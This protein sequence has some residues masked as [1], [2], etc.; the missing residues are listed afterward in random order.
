MSGIAGLLS[1][2]GG[3]IDRCLLGRLT[4]FM[5]FRGPDAQETWN[6]GRVGFGHAMLRTTFESQRERQPCS[7]DDRVW[8][9][10]DARVDGRSELSHKLRSA[11][12]EFQ[13]GAND[14]ELILYAYRAWGEECVRHLLGD[15]AFAIWDGPRERLF[16]ARDHFGVKPF[17][18][19]QAGDCAV[20]SNTLNCVRQHPAVSDELNELAIADFL[21]FDY[22]QDEATTAFAGIR[23]LPPAHRLS[24]SQGALRVERYWDLPT[25]GHLRYR[26]ACDY[27][28]HFTERF[29]AAVADRLRSDRIGVLMS[30]GLDS[31]SVAV[32]AQAL[33]AKQHAD[34]DLRAYTCVSDRLFVDEERHFSS[35]AADAL[36]I[37]IHYL[38]ADNYALFEGWRMPGPPPPGP[39]NEPLSALYLD[40]ARQMASHCRV[41]LTGWDGDAL[42]NESV[43]AC[44]GILRMTMN[45]A[46]RAAL[47]GWR[48]LSQGRWPRPDLRARLVRMLS[49]PPEEGFACPEWLRPDLVERLDLPA[50]WREIQESS[51]PRDC[52]HQEAHSTLTSPILTSLLESYDPGVMGIPVEAR[53]PLLDVRVV[54]YLLSLPASPWCVNKKLLR[55]AMNGRLP[56]SIRLRPKTLLAGNPV[57]ELL[58]R[59]DA[60][61]VDAFEAAPTLGKYID[62]AAVPPVAGARDS[63]QVWTDLRPLC[64]NLWLQQLTASGRVYRREEYHEAV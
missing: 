39:A 21:L 47:M 40:Q 19:A 4:K 22:N 44:G 27:V 42:L 25:D 8:I 58:Q 48:A 63:D 15:F 1:L 51:R 49:G 38:V 17:Y 37:P 34:F 12:H 62:R 54:E 43:N 7:L 36:G 32:T 24:W 30:G 55:M 29:N 41:A 60:H 31:T 20:F 45:L 56:E 28:D 14:A 35:L 18:Y 33:L 5:Q 13:Q 59:A 64:L 16:C 50:R 52:Q 10:A 57:I 61:W 6:G 2:D 9:V 53:H 46:R 26:R 3:P 23:R 11:G